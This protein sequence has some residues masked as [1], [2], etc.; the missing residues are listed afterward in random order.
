MKLSVAIICKNEESCIETCLKSIQEADEIIVVD[1]GST[2]NT[3][4]VCKKH[5]NKVFENEYCWEDSF[6]KARNYALSKVTE[7]WVL[8]LDCDEY[9]EIGGIA[10][11]RKAIEFAESH[12][13]KTI[14][15]IMEANITGDQFYFPRLFKRCKEIYWKGNIHNYLS[16]TDNNKS[17][18]KITFGYSKAHQNDPD[19]ALRIL[20]QELN[21]N[22]QLV[23]ETFYLAREYWYR[24]DWI[25]AIYWYKDYLTRA[26]WPPEWAEAWLM[27]ARCYWE[28]NKVDEAKDACLGA[29][30]VNAGF[31]EAIEF[32]ADLCGPKNKAQW[33]AYASLS[34]NENVLTIRNKE[35]DSNYYDSLFRADSNM[36]RYYHLYNFMGCLIGDNKTLDIGC[37]CGK[38]SNFVTDYYGFDFASETIKSIN[39]PNIFVGN[40]Y[41]KKNYEGDYKVFVATE[42]LEHIDD[43]KLINNLPIGVRF[44]F[45]VPNFTDP[46]HVRIYTEAIIRTRFKNILSI[47]KITRFNW[48]N[49]QW[50][51]DSPE[52]ENY[53]LLVE[54]IKK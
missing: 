50:Q 23:R 53:I 8:S 30:K 41:D 18:I 31:K 4:K 36:F 39:K 51:T 40:I 33:L 28:L 19:R 29:I 26:T 25:Q 16:Y 5:T 17:D 13:Q 9:L 37:G 14:N 54:S 11:I 52:T 12:N 6:C 34:S 2:D 35:K 43:F 48:C 46:S 27:L 1:T 10:K 20:K 24:K 7:G 22:P 45:S 42:V 38:L 47:E 15:V 21:N 32:M 49:N 44:I 3:V